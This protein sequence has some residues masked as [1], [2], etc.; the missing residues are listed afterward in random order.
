MT[1]FLE[2]EIDKNTVPFFGKKKGACHYRVFNLCKH[3]QASEIERIITRIINGEALL[4][5][6]EGIFTKDGTYFVVLKWA[7]PQKEI[8]I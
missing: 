7:E 5:R 1:D 3:Y 6:E 2:K 8:L 4:L